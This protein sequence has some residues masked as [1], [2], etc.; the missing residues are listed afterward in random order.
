M[1]TNNQTDLM[2]EQVTKANIW[3][4]TA[5]LIAIGDVRERCIAQ[6][7]EAEGRVKH[8]LRRSSCPEVEAAEVEEALD[9]LSDRL[10]TQSFE[11]EERDW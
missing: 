8:W 9:G 3:L 2:L 5:E 6:A 11:E 10:A 4:D 7:F 1:H